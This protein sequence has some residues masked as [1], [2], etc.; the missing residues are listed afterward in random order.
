MISN[1]GIGL[2]VKEQ[3][4]IF[5]RF[6]RVTETRSRDVQGVGLGLSI[7]HS[8]VDAHGG[9]I[10]VESIPGRGSTFRIVLPICSSESC[11][12]KISS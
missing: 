7:A 4:Q 3:G 8:I 10:E 2:S 12:G 11:P 5:S 6:H 1:T 9:R